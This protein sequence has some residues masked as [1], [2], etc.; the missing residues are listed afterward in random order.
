MTKV[1]Y[2]YHL[3]E[4]KQITYIKMPV[5]AEILCCK[6]QNNDPCVWAIVDKDY[7]NT[8][9]R[10]FLILPTGASIPEHPHLKLPGEYID[11]IQIHE[12]GVELVFHIFEVT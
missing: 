4:P 9:E 12:C 5:G 8:E 2:K 6:V 10:I 11:T 1:I 3:S 7:V